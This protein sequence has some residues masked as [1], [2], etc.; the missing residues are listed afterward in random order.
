MP[1][2][3][4]LSLVDVR[5]RYGPRVAVDGVS[6]DVRRGEI[7][8]L[9][10]PNGSGKSTVIAAAAG[11]LD[12]F[13]GTVRVA[14][15]DRAVDPVGFAHK[16]GLVPQECGLYEELTA[17]D[18]LVFF[19]KLYGLSGSELRRRVARVLSR[20]RMADRALHRVNTLSGGMKQRLNLAVALMHD[21]LVLLLDEPTAALDP[22]SRDAFFADLT[23]LRDEGHA[24]LLSTHHLDEAELGCDRIAE[25]TNGNLTACGEPA[26]LLRCRKADRPLLYGHLRG[27]PP[28]FLE[29]AIRERLG[30]DIGFEV[31]GR[32]LRLTAPTAEELGQA[33][34]ALLSEGVELEAY[35]TPA[36]T[37]ERVLRG[38]TETAP[39]RTG[40]QN[41][42]G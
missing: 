33:L 32:R 35:R 31:T 28:K 38:G 21:P 1:L 20:V 16:V 2:P 14:D 22:A 26:E 6:L 39:C 37:L 36:G 4:A 13:D 23:H 11:V 8:G 30:P 42:D 3:V 40:A 34:A 18:N 19:G 10:G 24:V 7:V 9:L 12:P 29:R 41:G 17:A 25:L 5:V 15:V 27:R